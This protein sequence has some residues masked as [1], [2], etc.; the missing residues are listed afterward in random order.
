MTETG[1]SGQHPQNGQ[2]LLRGT[3]HRKLM[4]KT[5]AGSRLK[6]ASTRK[7]NQKEA[8]QALGRHIIEAQPR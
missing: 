8:P 3:K 5:L 6:G 2:V 1:T 7:C 4:G